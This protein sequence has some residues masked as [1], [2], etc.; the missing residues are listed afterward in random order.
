MKLFEDSAAVKLLIKDNPF[1]D[2][3]P[4]HIRIIKR[5]LHFSTN[6]TSSHWWKQKKHD[7]SPV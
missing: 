2:K 6:S 5:Y 3:P 4:T 7:G 1:K